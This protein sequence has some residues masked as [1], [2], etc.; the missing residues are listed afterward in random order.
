MTRNEYAANMFGRNLCLARRRRGLSQEKLAERTGLW[1]D[2]I[3][4]IE[5]GQRSP[6]LDTL[7]TLADALRVDAAE[8]LSD[9]RP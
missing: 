6:R 4:K 2:T 3:Y 5:I 1:G 8:L 7:L 9:L